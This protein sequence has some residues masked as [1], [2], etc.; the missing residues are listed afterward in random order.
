MTD[1]QPTLRVL[2]LDPAAPPCVTEIPAADLT[3]LQSLVGG[4]LEAVYG[5][6]DDERPVVLYVNE[7]GRRLNLPAND[8]ATLVWRWS[9]PAVACCNDLLGTVVVVGV[10]GCEDAD[11]PERAVTA[12]ERLWGALAFDRA[13]NGWEP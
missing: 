10:N 7:D 9:N 5:M 12:A 3:A 13:V 6:T 2:V 11:V 1:Q 8:T 4:Y